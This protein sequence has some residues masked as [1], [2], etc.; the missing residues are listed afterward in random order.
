[1][2]AIFIHKEKD[3]R[4]SAVEAPLVS[5]NQLRVKIERGG[6]CGS[7]LHY[8][9]NGGFGTNR[10]KEPMILGHEVS[11]TVVELGSDASNFSLGD[12]VAVSPSRACNSCQF[13]LQGLANHCL[14][15]QF[16]GSAMPFP[17]IQGAFREQLVVRESQC[18]QANGLDASQAAMV[19]PLAVVLHA[20]KQ[21]GP[22]HGK[23]ILITGAGP[24]GL[25]AILAAKSAGAL[26]IVVTDISNQALKVAKGLGASETINVADN[27]AE[28]NK[29]SNSKGLFEIMFECSGS[30]QALLGAI[31][32]IRPRGV[33]VQLGMSGDMRVPMQ[34]ITTKEI[35]L[36]GSFRFH[37]EFELGVS[38]MMNGS[39]DVL[40]L[41]SHSIP[42]RDAV[43]AF[44][45]ANDRTKSMKVQIVF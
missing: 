25:L 5:S 41:L 6:I 23:N 4:I 11:G 18:V 10:L 39:I 7:D 44:E 21:A 40:P 22:V 14:D 32:C 19:E 16:Y 2:D 35:T 9:N 1:M 42:F 34:F 24:I 36:K 12:L 37:E 15:M 30:E 13:C 20:L 33:I 38:L 28:L 45:L 29:F 31:N 8:Y 27:A 26:N 43:Q 3:L 17:H